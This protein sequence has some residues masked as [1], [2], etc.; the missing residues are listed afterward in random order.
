MA[1]RL[2]LRCGDWNGG[3]AVPVSLAL[4]VAFTSACTASGGSGDEKA[5][6]S[7][8]VV[9]AVPRTSAPPDPGE[10][11]KA[12]ALAAYKGYW[13]ELPKAFAVPAI[14]GTDLKRYT[15]A[16][17][18]NE[19]VAGVKNLRNTKSVMTGTPVLTNP[20]VTDAALDK[21]TPNVTIS[22]CLDV[23][24]WKV[25]DNKSGKVAEMPSNRV[26]K[27]MVVSLLERWDGSWKVL[28]D[29]PQPEQAC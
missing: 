17:A 1:R 15:A 23:R 6:S 8:P 21:K 27:Y 11:A 2:E 3:R 19:A 13:R 29:T 4:C 16:D 28:R 7:A 9:S 10:V 22:S 24:N 12:Q 26:T 14:E 5:E 18:L 25:V 20:T